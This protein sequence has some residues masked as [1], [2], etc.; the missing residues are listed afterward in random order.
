WQMTPRTALSLTAT[1]SV[2][3]F[4]GAS[5]S[6][7]VI[8]SDTYGLQSYL[9]HVLTPRLTGTVGYYFTYLDFHFQGQGASTTQTSA[10][11]ASRTHIPTVGL[12][13][14]LT[15]TLT[16]SANGGPAI[17]EVGGQTFLSPA[18]NASLVQVLKIGSAS[19]QYN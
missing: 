18:G 2:L 5:R 1:Y 14:R 8:D 7:N 3:R 15:P 10:P 17:T 13:Y 6:S 12:S 4:T 16:V 11:G 19:V 9:S